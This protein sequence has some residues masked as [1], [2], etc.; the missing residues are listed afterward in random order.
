MSVLLAPYRGDDGGHRDRC[1]EYV[2]NWWEAQLQ[3]PVFTGD[4]PG[5]FNR[6]AARNDAARRAGD[7][8]VAI[9]VDADTIMTGHDA[10]APVHQAV[11]LARDT[12]TVV[13]PHTRYI[14]LTSSGTVRLLA[15]T[16]WRRHTKYQ[17]E[18]VPLGVMV[19]SRA[20]WDTLGGFDERFT[21]WGGE[22]VAFRVAAATLVGLRRLPGTLL[23]LWHP[24]DLS[25]A[26]YVRSRGGPLRQEYRVASGNPAA[27]R[28]LLEGR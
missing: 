20:A 8:Q 9:F 3:L 10:V 11:A 28:K 16:S 1:W 6:A 23:H 12:G 5:P 13:L 17:R 26:E 24:R 2:R 4:V 25:K 19:V 14:A 7:W 15:G 22:D 18:D 27:M 21:T